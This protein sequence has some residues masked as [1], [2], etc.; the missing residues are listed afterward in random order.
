M[1]AR[2]QETLFFLLP[3]YAYSTVVPS[4]NPGFVALLATLAVLAAS[5][6]S[7]MGGCERPGLRPRESGAL[8]A[9]DWRMV[10]RTVGER[11]LGAVR[12]RLG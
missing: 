2:P 11:A 3:F 9:G 8:E 6:W 1:S 7:S 10:L 12:V 5:T 4:W